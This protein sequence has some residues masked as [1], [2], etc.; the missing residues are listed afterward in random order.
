MEGLIGDIGEVTMA[1]TPSGMVMVQ[2]ELWSAESPGETIEKG[3]KVT[4]RK[5]EN[6]KLFVEKIN[7]H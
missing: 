1:L 3:E 2:G 5:I 6:L 4:I 7:H